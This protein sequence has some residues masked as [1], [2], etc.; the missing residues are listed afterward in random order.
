MKVF[1][2]SVVIVAF[3]LTDEGSLLNAPKWMAEATENADQPIKFLIG[4]KRD[5]LVGIDCILLFIC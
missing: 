4:M 1:F 3:D 5:L 2:I